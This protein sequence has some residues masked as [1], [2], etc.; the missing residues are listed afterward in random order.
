M[1]QP[2]F[3]KSGPIIIDIGSF[4]QGLSDF[5]VTVEDLRALLEN[6]AFQAFWKIG[7]EKLLAV[8]QGIRGRLEPGSE[9]KVLARMN[10]LEELLGAVQALYENGQPDQMSEP[11]G[12]G[13]AAAQRRVAQHIKETFPW[14]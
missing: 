3:R 7:M 10:A 6:P 4:E 11:D 12:E 9:G 5:P 1:T 2:N 13:R 14:L 8:H